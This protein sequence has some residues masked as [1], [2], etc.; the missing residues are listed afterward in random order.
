MN[1]SIKGDTNRALWAEPPHHRSTKQEELQINKDQLNR[2]HKEN[3]APKQTE[4]S[5]SHLKIR[6]IF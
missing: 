4:H 5:Q 1:Q 6:K 3:I 2:S